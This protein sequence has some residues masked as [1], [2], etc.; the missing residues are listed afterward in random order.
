M[1]QTHN[2]ADQAAQAYQQNIQKTYEAAG[3]NITE[4][5]QKSVEKMQDIA[6][7]SQETKNEVSDMA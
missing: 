6:N 2:Q 7:Q 5:G 3:E 4:Y 1:Q